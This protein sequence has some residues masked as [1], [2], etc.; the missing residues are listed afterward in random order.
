MEPFDEFFNNNESS[1]MPPRSAIPNTPLDKNGRLVPPPI[2]IETKTVFK[3]GSLIPPSTPLEAQEGSVPPS[4]GVTPS[5]DGP[6]ANAPQQPAKGG[7]YKKRTAK[8]HHSRKRR[9]TKSRKLRR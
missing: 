6:Y 8:K 5:K 2:Q 9:V 1:G 7:K 4:K 3:N